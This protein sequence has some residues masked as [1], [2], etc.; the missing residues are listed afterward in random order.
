MAVIHVGAVT[1]ADSASEALD[2]NSS[3]MSKL[4]NTLKEQNV[5]EKDIQTSHFSIA[6]RHEH[7]PQRPQSGKIVG[8]EVTNQV[9]IKV[10]NLKNLGQLLDEVV[11]KGANQVHGIRF[12]VD[13]PE[14][15][16]NEA[17]R[18]AIADAR[19]KAE[20][21]AHA[22]DLEI[23]RTLL[24]QEESSGRPQ[25]FEF[26]ALSQRQAMDVPIAPGE[27]EFEAKI[28]VTYRLE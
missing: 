21:Y 10:R 4:I 3:A 22:N 20:L 27:L 24:I 18:K 25:P 14:R 7:D 12:T 26:R 19:K 17:R 8:Y 23:G 1:Q 15:L 2:Q 11:S 5:A 6:P 16:M 9:Q 13:E 28:E